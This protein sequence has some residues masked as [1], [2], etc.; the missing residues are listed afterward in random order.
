MK[1]ILCLLSLLSLLI[2]MGCSS[3][4]VIWYRGNTHVH[5]TKCNHADSHPDKVAQWYLDNGYNFLVLSEHNY[6]IDPETVNLPK[7]RRKD[8]LLVPGMEVTGKK[9]IHTTAMNVKKIVPWKFDHE[10]KHQ[11]IQNHVDG[12]K[13]EGGQAILNHPNFRHALAFQH[14]SKVRNLYMFE[15]FNGHP[16]VHSHGD[17]KADSTEVLWDKLLTHGMLIYGV[18]SDD[19]HQFKTIKKELSNPGR[20]WVMVDSA[21]ILT[22]DALT[23]AML[24]GSFYASN[25]V[26]LKTY[27]RDHHEYAIEIDLEKTKKEIAKKQVT[28]KVVTNSKE[29]IKIEFIADGGKVLSSHESLSASF[30]IPKGIS[31]IRAKVT[32]TKKEND[33]LTEFYAWGQPT[34]LDDRKNH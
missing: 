28:G 4:K 29:G 12:V 20:G 31:Y 17:E 21:G 32:Y 23:N 9:A 19:A 10:H 30:E 27:E 13:A 2:T 5:T 3:S 15:L 26:F 14:I 34:F 8:F 6:F 22:S 18:S 11:I 24:H 1:K 7:D 33:I 16:H 25:G